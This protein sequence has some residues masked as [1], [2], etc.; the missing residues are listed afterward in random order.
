[1]LK[2]RI[3]RN[4]KHVRK[5]AEAVYAGELFRLLAARPPGSRWRPAIPRHD[6]VVHLGQLHGETMLKAFEFAANGG[7]KWA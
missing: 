6:G 5:I 2:I 3:R 1:M 7:I 4:S